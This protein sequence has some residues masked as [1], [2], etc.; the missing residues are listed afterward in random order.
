MVSYLENSLIQDKQ[1]SITD[2]FPTCPKISLAPQPFGASLPSL[3]PGGDDVLRCRILG[4]A[5]NLG[6]H[7]L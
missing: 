1:V 5:D 3:N 2:V 6:P 7:R 4:R